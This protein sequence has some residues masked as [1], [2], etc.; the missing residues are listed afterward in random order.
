MK[1]C[2]EPGCDEKHWA[3]GLCQWHYSRSPEV[4]ARNRNRK[5]KRRKHEIQR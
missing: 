3:K 2:T 4:L 1:G 5:K